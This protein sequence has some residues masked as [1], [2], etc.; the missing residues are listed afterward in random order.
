MRVEP[1]DLLDIKDNSTPNYNML[2]NML[3]LEYNH[4][5]QNSDFRNIFKAE[6]NLEKELEKF[7][8]FLIKDGEFPLI[9]SNVTELENNYF[10]TFENFDMSNN[11]EINNSTLTSN[12][13]YQILQPIQNLPKEKLIIDTIKLKKRG[14]LTKEESNKNDDPSVHNKYE[15]NNI[16]MKVK[17]HS[18]NNFIDHLNLMLKDSENNQINSIHLK[19]ID[20]TIIKVNSKSDNIKLLKMEMSVIFSGRISKRFKKVDPLYNEKNIDLILKIGDEEIKNALKKTFNDTIDL[21]SSKKTDIYR[22]EE[23][24]KL[25]NDVEEFRNKGEDE[26]YIKKYIDIAKNFKKK[27]D[28]IDQRRPRRRIKE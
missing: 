11:P 10:S 1:I 21:Y 18:S 12:T 19:H 15:D 23:L 6:R 16:I 28:E 13:N 27:I 20:P 25:E 26:A 7:D 4:N 3:T 9:N 14:R 2:Y 22:F 17:V 24:K 8:D 5:K